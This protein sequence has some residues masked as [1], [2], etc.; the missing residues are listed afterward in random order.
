MNE[1]LRFCNRILFLQLATIKRKRLLVSFLYETDRLMFITAPKLC[2]FHTLDQ[3]RPW[4]RW[5]YPAR[6]R[7]TSP[8]SLGRRTTGLFSQ[9]LNVSFCKQNGSFPAHYA[10]HPVGGLHFAGAERVRSKLLSLQQPRAALSTTAVDGEAPTH[11]TPAT[12][13]ASTRILVVYCDALYRFDYT[14]LQVSA[15][16]HNYIILDAG[17]NHPVGLENERRGLCPVVNSYRL[18]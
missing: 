13:T 7:H 15:F 10:I 1:R 16:F 11:T 4:S 5:F 12:T 17:G 8:P 2:H 6:V 9:L 18:R 3:Y 14:F